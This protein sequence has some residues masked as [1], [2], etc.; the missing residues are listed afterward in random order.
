LPIVTAAVHI[1]FAFP[2]ITKLFKLFYMTNIALFAWC[3]LGALLM[4]AAIYAAIYALT[5]RAYYQ[6][7][8]A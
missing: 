3:T 1:A 2:M 5:A 4:F 8:K 6:I 7:V